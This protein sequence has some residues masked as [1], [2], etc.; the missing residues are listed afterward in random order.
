MR[1]WTICLACVAA[2]PLAAAGIDCSDSQARQLLAW[3]SAVEKNRSRITPHP[4]TLEELKTTGGYSYLLYFNTKPK[5]KY[6]RSVLVVMDDECNVL[7]VDD[8]LRESQIILT[9][10][11]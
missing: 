7:H 5:R 3:E 6:A 4:Y 10:G 2:L 1:F 11:M 9:G 8:T